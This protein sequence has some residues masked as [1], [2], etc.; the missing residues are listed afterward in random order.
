M[1]DLGNIW[2]ALTAIG[3]ILLFLAAVAAGIFA[4]KNLR[5][6]RQ[7]LSVLREG[8]DLQ[9]FSALIKE[10]S[11]ETASRDRGLV[12]ENIAPG[13]K[14]EEIKRLVS[15]GRSGKQHIGALSGAA[16]E[17]TIARL[18]RVGFFLFGHGNKPRMEPPV[19]LWTITDDMWKRLG[20]WV[21]YR[22]S[23][24]DDQTFWHEGYS[25]YFQKLAEKARKRRARHTTGTGQE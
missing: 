7:Q 1:I 9:I 24:K 4:W 23:A 3:T 11:D 13:E 10:I 15:E 12:K 18:D 17:R 14:V 8:I 25:L 6:Y 5:A 16:A 19:W 22:Q 2:E 20:E 21:K